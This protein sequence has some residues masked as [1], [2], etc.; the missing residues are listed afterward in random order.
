MVEIRTSRLTPEARPA[1]AVSTATSE[2][3]RA[4]A[5]ATQRAADT[6]SAFYEAEAQRQ[7]ELI[8]AETSAEFSKR[9]SD[10]AKD[11]GEGYAENLVQQF[12]QYRQ[13]RIANAPKRGRDDL[14][15]ALDK[16][17]IKLQSRAEEAEAAAAARRA[18]AAAAEA[19][20]AREKQL[21]ADVRA[22][23][24]GLI[25]NPDDAVLREYVEQYPDQ[26]DDFVRVYNAAR[27]M[28][29]PVGVAEEVKSGKWDAHYTPSQK[30]QMIESGAAAAAKIER[31]NAAARKAALAD[32]GDAVT[33]EAAFVEANGYAPGDGYAANPEALDI[34]L[35]QLIPDEQER[36]RVK[37][38]VQ[39]QFEGARAVHSA[40]VSSPDEISAEFERLSARVSEPGQ[41]P[42][43]VAALNR[44]AAAIDA[45]NKSITDDAAAH[46]MRSNDE[47]AA[48]FDAVTTASDAEEA[49]IAA[50]QA[51]AA[52]GSEYDRL[53][54]APQFRRLIPKT[55]AQSIV[56]DLHNEG[57]DTLPQRLAALRDTWNDPRLIAELSA[58]GLNSH[59]VV[60]LRHADNPGLATAILGVADLDLPELK[61][62]TS[63]EIVSAVNMELPEAIAE[64]REVFEQGDET[65]AAIN[66]MNQ[67]TMVAEKLIYRKIRAGIDPSVAVETVVG[68]L[69]PEGVINTTQAKVLVP[70]EYSAI[71]VEARLDAAISEDAIRAFNPA[72]LDDPMFMEFQNKELI[73]KAATNGVWLNNS[74][75]TGAVLNIDLG[76]FYLPITD[77]SG[78]YYEV[79][80]ADTAGQ[81]TNFIPRLSPKGARPVHPLYRDGQ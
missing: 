26:A 12:D 62:N 42:E 53:G 56:Q 79:R 11:A 1:E 57:I 45:R 17:R 51:K 7:N 14:G 13:E 29:D 61:R 67:N 65:G 34:Q 74:D 36:N 20:R 75:G 44:Y 27:M 72:A 16:Y 41:T 47:V 25:S 50:N 35:E 28:D 38:T 64:Y 22:A 2:G 60:A 39:D 77:E 66:I 46:V 81:S 6:F 5:G 71:N 40:A 18:A 31:E 52:I 23:Q 59:A 80:F 78:R 48:L 15:F 68:S 63:T 24:N 43:D 70:E 8:V 3:L 54:V 10:T 58:A 55:F 9:F 21:A 4:M 69:F 19:K 33:E 37:R 32:L 30:I 49:G 73:V 76:G